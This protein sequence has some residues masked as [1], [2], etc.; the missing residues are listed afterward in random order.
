MFVWLHPSEPAV[1]WALVSAS[2]T[3][4]GRKLKDL[5]QETM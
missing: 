5:D 3:S 2:R 4:S 1:S